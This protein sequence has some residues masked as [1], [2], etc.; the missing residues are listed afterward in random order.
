MDFLIQY[1]VG[2]DKVAEQEVA[3]RE[4]VA[5]VKAQADPGYRYTVSRKQDGVSFV[6]YTWI[7]DEAANQ[8]FRGQPHFKPH[9][10]PAVRRRGPRSPG[11]TVLRR[12]RIKSGQRPGR[13]R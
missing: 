8:R 12:P 2:A 13:P 11:S 10:S 1:R 3:I 4:F 7:A 9:A 5:A 6:H